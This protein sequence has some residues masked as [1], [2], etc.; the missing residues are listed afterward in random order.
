[1]R[2]NR[3]CDGC[4][5]RQKVSAKIVWKCKRCGVKNLIRRSVPIKPMEVKEYR[6][7]YKAHPSP[8]PPKKPM[9]IFEGKQVEMGGRISLDPPKR[10]KRD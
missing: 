5:H 6:E 8:S 1:M 10:L 2:H 9:E 7:V 4:G 3:K